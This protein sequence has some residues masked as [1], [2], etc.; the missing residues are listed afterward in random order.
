[1][2]EAEARRKRL[3]AIR[4]D[5]QKP[6]ED[7]GGMGKLENPL[8][9]AP[10]AQDLPSGFSFYS[11]PVGALKARRAST[12]MQPKQA[13]APAPGSGPP[14]LHAGS[15][16]PF[17]KQHASSSGPPV[18]PPAHHQSKPGLHVMPKFQMNMQWQQG[19][20]AAQRALGVQPQWHQ[21]PG[22]P[23]PMTQPR[24]PPRPPEPWGYPPRAP[25]PPPMGCGGVGVGRGGGTLGGGRGPSHGGSSIPSRGVGRQQSGRGRGR[26]GGFNVEAYYQ[27]SML[28]DPWKHLRQQQQEPPPPHEAAQHGI[29]D[30]EHNKNHDSRSSAE[31]DADRPWH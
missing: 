12:S 18:P 28:E 16:N 24:P 30:Q 25:Y 17:G 2:E 3:K 10:A 13:P 21:G 6:E 20:A 31:G 1:M 19:V 15:E 8:V 23:P 4:E 27:P 14:G 9:D 22:R 5:V 7:S 29:A 26:E 11:D